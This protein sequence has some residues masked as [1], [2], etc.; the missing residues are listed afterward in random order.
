MKIGLIILAAGY[1][2]RMGVLKPLLPVGNESALRRAVGL[3]RHEKVHCISVVTGFRCEDVEAELLAAHAKN[4]R[5]V[6]NSR[7]DEGMFSSVRAGIHSLPADLDA[8]LLLPVDHCAVHQETLEKVI[9]AFILQNGEA[10]VYP[11]HG[12]KRGHPPLIPYRFV[13]ALKSYDGADGMRGYL[14]RFPAA[15]VEVDD[16]GSVMDMDTPED[17]EAILNYLVL[18]V[19]P[20]E[21][22]CRRLAEKYEMPENVA[23]H[24]RQV[25]V[26]AL[27][28]AGLLQKKGVEIDRGLLSSACLLHDIVRLQP[29]HDSAGAKLLLLEGY[30]ATAR[31]IAGHMDL[32]E[33]Y[34]PKPDALS[35]L[36]LA[37]KLSRDGRFVP[38]YVTREE[39]KRRFDG[40]PAALARAD[41]RMA[42]AQSIL[43][44]LRE[45]YGISYQDI[46]PAAPSSG[47]AE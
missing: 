7:Y 12:G 15:D 17:Y 36:Y 18:P 38:V 23:A 42:R 26:L 9:D 47:A 13:S 46:A 32:P 35:L 1:S 14:S 34:L 25:N 29:N 27:R 4:I 39:L 3:G 45:R 30:P 33:G 8:F 37:D 40:N 21:D 44:M 2:E 31:L 24:C 11:T 10:V 41:I 16:A 20:G 19:Y 28:I 43:D 6:F 5:H 22:A